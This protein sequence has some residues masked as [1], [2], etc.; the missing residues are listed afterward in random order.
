MAPALT[1]T[2]HRQEGSGADI[3]ISAFAQSGVSV[4]LAWVVKKQWGTEPLQSPW[5]LGSFLPSDL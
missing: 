1:P 5:E 2:Q 4:R 3:Q